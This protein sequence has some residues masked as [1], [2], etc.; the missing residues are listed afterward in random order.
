[1]TAIDPDG[2]HGPEPFADD[3]G[4]RVAVS[5]LS[6]AVVALQQA[7]AAVLAVDPRDQ[8]PGAALADTEAVLE[9][10]RLLRVGCLDRIADVHDRELFDLAGARSSRS[11]LLQAQPDADPSDALF[12][13]ATRDFVELRQ[14]VAKSEVPIAAA[15]KV[16]AALQRAARWMRRDSIEGIPLEQVIAG[17]VR[18]VVPLVQQSVLAY[19]ADDIRLWALVEETE[20]IVA[21]AG[22]ALERLEKAYTL[23]ASLVPLEDLSGMLDDLYLAMVPAELERREAEAFAQRDLQLR[24]RPDGMW[25]LRGRLTPECAEYLYTCLQ[26][27][28]RRDELNPLDTATAEALRQ[29]GLDPFDPGSWPVEIREQVEARGQGYGDAGPATEPAAPR[30]RGE[31]WHDALQWFARHYLDQ[32]LGGGHHKAAAHIGVTVQEQSLPGRP[33]SLPAKGGS[34]QSVSRSLLRR[35]WCDSSVTAYV[36]AKGGKALRSIYLGRTLTGAQ[37]KALLIEQGNRCAGAHCCRGSTGAGP[38]PD[39]R[40][41]HVRRWC[42]DRHSWLE[43]TVMVCDVLHRDL[44][45][46]G[47][48]VRLWNGRLISEQGW[49]ETPAFGPLAPF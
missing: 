12:A 18:S 21:S 9:C 8:K 15:K 46:G 10:A 49:V 24:Q 36:L 40:P 33:G 11:W 19:A 20:A 28:R 26:A 41:H 34:G 25:D 38:Q 47:K 4:D 29:Q 17:V 30:S 14:A 6:A 39:L 48:T 2:E 45:E 31:R 35:W 27:A 32:G 3:E 44:H 7:V 1:M 5:G 37:R 43:E 22:T 16:S 13:V 23:L 42:E